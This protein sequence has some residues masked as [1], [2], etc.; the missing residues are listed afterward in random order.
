M[1]QLFP[2]ACPLPTV[3]SH[4][5]N[6]QIVTERNC[7]TVLSRHAELR[8]KWSA[9]VVSQPQL[10]QLLLSPRIRQPK[11]QVPTGSRNSTSSMRC[12]PLSHRTQLLRLRRN[13]MTRTVFVG[14]SV[15]AQRTVLRTRLAHACG[16]FQWPETCRLIASY[17]GREWRNWRQGCKIG[18]RSHHPPPDS[19]KP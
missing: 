3:A 14:A 4:L 9:C 18:T 8:R 1:W 13:C 2:H 17:G 16:T 7:S 10:T 12:I 11:N 6:D 15:A 5:P 19:C